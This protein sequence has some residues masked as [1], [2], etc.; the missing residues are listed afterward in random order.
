MECSKFT[1]KL[2]RLDNLV[3]DFTLSKV[4]LNLFQISLEKNERRQNQ[5]D[6][7][8]KSSFAQKSW[9][10]I[11]V[12]KVNEELADSLVKINRMLDT[13]EKAISISESSK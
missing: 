13:F 2:R 10:E 7:R 1:E 8:S 9:R 5:A 4:I 12:D 3:S 6:K 11:L